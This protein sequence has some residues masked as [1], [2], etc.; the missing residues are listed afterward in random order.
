MFVSFLLLSLSLSLSLI[1]DASMSAKSTSCMTLGLD[2]E[3]NRLIVHVSGNNANKDMVVNSLPVF[4]MHDSVGE[5]IVI[6]VLDEMH[7]LQSFRIKAYKQRVLNAGWAHDAWKLIEQHPRT[8]TTTA[9]A[10][11]IIPPSGTTDIKKKLQS[12][13]A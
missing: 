5:F 11:G 10:L 4:D 9:I 12:L 8:T 3:S 6:N 13:R 2:H 1:C 7:S